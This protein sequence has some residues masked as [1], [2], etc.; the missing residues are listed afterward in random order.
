[1][2]YN[3]GLQSGGRT[4][5]LYLLKG[6]NFIKFAGQSIEGYSSVI[7][8]KYQKNGKWSNTTY[9]LELFP[10]VR[11]LEMLSPLHGIWGEWFLS[12][13]DACERLCLPIES[14]QEII[15]T[16]Y[17]STVRRLDKIEDFAMKL[18]EAS[19][20]ESEIVIVSFGTPTNRSIREGYWEQEKS[21]QTS[22]GQPVVIVP[23]KGEFGP[24]WN[25][26]SVLS[27]EGSRVVSSV[28]KPGMHGGYWTVE[29]MV[30][31]LNKS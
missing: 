15:R 31:V 11:A 22:D 3:N 23:A 13:G 30:P 20:V 24:D 6:S 16:E 10:G 1:M 9:Q 19:S 25:N 28:H 29:V 14:V 21:S 12:W 17:P 5:R 2:E 8:E 27:P 18:E 7:T 26:P 4:P